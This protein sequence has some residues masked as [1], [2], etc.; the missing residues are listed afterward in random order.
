M[1]IWA[2]IEQKISDSI[3]LP[4]QFKNQ[5]GISG[6]SINQAWR[7]EGQITEVNGNRSVSYFI[8]FNNKNRLNMFEAEAAGLHEME[9]AQAIRVPRVIC[10][11]VEEN[12]SYLVLENL[13]L[14]RAQADSAARLGQQLAR[15]HQKTAS[16][17][18]WSRDNTIGSTKQL[19]TQISKGTH[20][21]I[22]F[23]REHRLGFQLQLA[24]Q[25]GAGGSL[26]R[27]G[28]K[29]LDQ[30]ESFFISYEPEASLLHGDLW[31]GN[32]GYLENG[33]PVIFDPAV[34]YGD[35]EADLAMTELFGGFPSAFYSA[36]NETWPLDDGYQ[37]RKHL[38]NLYHILNHYNMFGGGYGSQAERMLD[39]LLNS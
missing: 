20:H 32:A 24:Q 21:W 28:E 30:L 12:Q 3:D 18:G 33:E 26:T 27:K 9:Q 31:S 35:R 8:K 38:Y 39:Q 22:E 2:G 34:Y 36:Y 25:N 4:F 5:V 15:M 13:S 11:G 1:S 16:Q 10:S 17:F 23:W 7:I 6:G 19:N 14:A 37:Q 29:L